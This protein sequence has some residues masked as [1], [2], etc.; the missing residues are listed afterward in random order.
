M[1]PVKQQLYQQMWDAIALSEEMRLLQ[2]KLLNMVDDL[3][4]L[5]VA[6][7]IWIKIKQ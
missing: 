2:D 3:I 4:W 5:R 1:K 7:Q 6:L